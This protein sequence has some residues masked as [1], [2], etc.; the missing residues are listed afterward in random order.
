MYKY[1]LHVHTSQTS[2]CASVSGAQQ[3]RAYKELG[4]TGI[5][6]TDH[7]YEGFFE[8][9][10]YP[11]WKE[12]MDCYF[13][14][15]FDAKAEGD[16]IGLDVFQCAEVTLAPIRMDYLVLGL[17]ADFFYRNEKLFRLTE[18]EFI[19]LVHA[20]GGLVFGAHPFRY[21]ELYPYGNIDGVEAVNGNPQ[22]RNELAIEYA[23]KNGLLMCAGSDA[24]NPGEQGTGGIITDRRVKNI[25]EFADIVRSGNYSFI[26]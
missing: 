12:S 20:E 17:E 6:I 4:F 15:Y 5:V 11:T 24:H 9:N 23:K 16:R 21:K 10:T 14:G 3:A 19:E 25:R 18:A 8:R 26:M 1:D 7:Y 22:S 2:P 13:A